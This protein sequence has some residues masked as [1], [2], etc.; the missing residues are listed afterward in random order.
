VRGASLMKD[1]A[2]EFEVGV[3]DI[4]CGIVEGDKA[5]PD[6]LWPFHAPKDGLRGCGRSWG[7]SVLPQR[8]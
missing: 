8:C 4:A 1:G 3:G 5:I 6:V 7:I 2:G